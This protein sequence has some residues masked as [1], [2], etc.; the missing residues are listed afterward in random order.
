[1]KVTTTAYGL[2]AARLRNVAEET[3]GGRL[4]VALEGGYDLEALGAS[5]AEVVTVLLAPRAPT[6]DFP[7]P[8]PTGRKLVARLRQAHASNWPTLLREVPE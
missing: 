2:F 8:T 6:G 4:V 7:L 1:M 3:C 5:V